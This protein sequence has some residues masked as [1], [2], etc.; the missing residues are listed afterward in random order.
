MSEPMVRL[1][2]VYKAYR[3][4]SRYLVVLRG[5]SLEVERGESVA[6]LGKSGS[7][8]TTLLNI[9]AGLDRPSYGHVYVDGVDLVYLSED[10]LARFR[11]SRVSFIFQSYNLIS[12]LTALE[13]VMLAQKARFGRTDREEALR[14]LRLVGLEGHANHR[15][16]EL[17]GGQQQR[18]AIA[19]ALA[20][21][22]KLIIADEPT[23]A[24]DSK[25]REQVLGLLLDV[26]D[27][28]GTT[29]LVVTHDVDVAR[30]MERIVR[31][32]DG[33]IVKAGGGSRG[34]GEASAPAPLQAGWSS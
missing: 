4:G 22:P 15:P 2:D 23:G 24:L 18:V 16:H 30:R 29:L 13:N 7:G 9:I 26:K 5:V 21:S 25:M 28:L 17:S 8:K 33:E 10:E 3:I 12:E 20:K 19:M 32:R 34:R 11:R 1:V 14:I 27:R 31:I 6:I